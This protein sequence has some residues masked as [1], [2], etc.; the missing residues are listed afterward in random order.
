MDLNVYSQVQKN[1]IQATFIPALFEYIPIP[2][3]VYL[4]V[5]FVFEPEKIW[6]FLSHSQQLAAFD[7]QKKEWTQHDVPPSIPKQ[8]IPLK[9]DQGFIWSCSSC[10]IFGE[11]NKEN[12][13]VVE[14]LSLVSSQ[15]K[16]TLYSFWAGDKSVVQL[17][18][19]HCGRMRPKNR[20]FQ[21]GVWSSLPT[22]CSLGLQKMGGVH[23]NPITRQLSIMGGYDHKTRAAL[24]T[25]RVMTTL[26]GEWKQ[27]PDLIVPRTKPAVSFHDESQSYLVSG[28]FLQSYP[29]RIGRSLLS[30]IERLDTVWSVLELKLPI[31]L[32]EHHMF[33][34]QSQL[35]VFGG[36]TSSEHGYYNKNMWA[37]KLTKDGFP[38]GPWILIDISTSP[39]PFFV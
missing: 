17:F 32:Y 5:S 7:L 11:F 8:A 35:F 2:P 25:C 19:I 29:D 23:W 27:L 20:I 38:C 28:G 14:T 36:Q 15:S 6:K 31:V 9:T 4:I 21:N 22:S 12:K 1:L 33:I 16:G 10:L 3:L 18:S 13:M 24:H 37:C 39:C 30:S 26:S 34:F